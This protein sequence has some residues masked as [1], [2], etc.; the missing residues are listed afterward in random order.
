METGDTK[1]VGGGGGGER[2]FVRLPAKCCEPKRGEPQE[3][4]TTYPAIWLS[5]PQTDVGGKK[6]STWPDDGSALSLPLSL[7]LGELDSWLSDWLPGTAFFFFASSSEHRATL[8][9][10]HSLAQSCN[11]NDSRLS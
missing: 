2:A 9:E 4:L 8:R 7:L 5:L 11:I 1:A 3:K 10:P 6:S